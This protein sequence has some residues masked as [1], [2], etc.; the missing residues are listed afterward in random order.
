M[1][2]DIIEEPTCEVIEDFSCPRVLLGLGLGIVSA[3]ISVLM[4][5]WNNAPYVVHATVGGLL[6]V[7]WC[8]AVGFLT[9]GSG[10]GVTAGSVYLE[11]WAGL[12]LSLD[13]ATTNVAHL[14][15]QWEAAKSLQRGAI[16]GAAADEGGTQEEDK[17]MELATLEQL[18]DGRRSSTGAPPCN[19]D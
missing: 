14:L 7:A 1:I 19:N 10:H 12:F 5:L 3:A 6:F 18:G 9:Y 13:V 16:E 8:F 17:T 4:L 2:G 11:S 15:R